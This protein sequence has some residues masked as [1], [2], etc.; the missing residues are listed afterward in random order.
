MGMI[1]GTDFRA[2]TLNLPILFTGVAVT[3]AT[4]VVLLLV[5]A[6]LLGRG[7][8]PRRRGKHTA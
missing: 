8:T 2:A 5:G 1:K 3:V 4:I 7:L 6:G